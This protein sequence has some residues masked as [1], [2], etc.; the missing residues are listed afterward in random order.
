MPTFRS[1]LLL[2]PL[3]LPAFSQQTESVDTERDVKYDATWESIDSRPTPQWWLDAKF[4]IFIHWGPYSVPAFSEVGRYS[5]WYWMD[6]VNPGRGSHSRQV[7]ENV[8][9]SWTGASPSVRS[10]KRHVCT[11]KAL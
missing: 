9:N 5:E 11:L 2:A 4:G 8:L 1:L 10:A 6:L 3:T 7:R